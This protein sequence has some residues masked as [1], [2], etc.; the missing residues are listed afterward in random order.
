MIS[1]SKDLPDILNFLSEKI[2]AQSLNFK[3]QKI[4]YFRILERKLNIYREFRSDIKKK[5]KTFKIKNQSRIIKKEFSAFLYDNFPDFF[6]FFINDFF[7][8]DCNSL[9]LILKEKISDTVVTLEYNYYLSSEEIDQFIDF[10]NKMGDNLQLLSF[11][12]YLLSLI[13]VLGIEI[14]RLIKQKI[15]ISL[16]CGVIKNEGGKTFLNFLILIREDKEEIFNNYFSMSL[17]Y[18]LKQFKG[19]PD[20]FY[21]KLLLGRDRLYQL[22]LNEYSESKKEELANL[23]FYFYKKCKLLQNIGPLLD[24]INF[25]CSRVEDSV[26]SKKDIIKRDFLEN[27][28][29]TDEKKSTIIKIFDFLDSRTSLYSTFQAN[30][31]P[32]PKAQLNL[33]LLYMKYFFSSGLEA[34]EVGNLLFLPEIFTITLNQHNSRE[35]NTIGASSIKNIGNFVNLLY[36]LSNIENLDLIFKKIFNA[37]VTELN[38]RFFRTFLRSFD[39]RLALIIEQENRN[40]SENPENDFFTFN[41][42]IDH[43]CRI[44]YT[45]IDKI[46]LRDNPDEASKNFIDRRGRYVGQNIALRVL[47]LFIFQ[48]FSFSDDIWPE[49]LVSIN[50]DTIKKNLKSFVDI[51]DKFFYSDDHLT[52]LQTLYNFQSLSTALFFEEWLIREII[53]P[54]SNFI[55]EIENSVKNL[56]KIEIY[57]KLREVFLDGVDIK[58][59]KITQEIRFVCQQLANFWEFSE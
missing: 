48:E 7:G 50:Q 3:S 24:L 55:S 57:E 22:A 58:G 59:E 52:K 6:K 20:E 19:I 2:K 26:F 33:F 38:Y 15:F 37:S 53:L 30:N 18:F 21:E 32:S 42:I 46:F 12:K 54:L 31:L 9:E 35:K 47:E 13:I 23:L 56:N 28:D 29:Y 36:V 41:I 17:Y 10:S 43:I 45:L 11:S 34:L 5:W 25:V 16:D 8:M 49:Y 4:A 14:R 51:P 39:T 27:L 40:L 44:L 1:V